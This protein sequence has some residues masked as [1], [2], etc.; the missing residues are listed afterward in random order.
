MDAAR[1]DRSPRPGLFGSVALVAVWGAVL[2]VVTLV[3][4]LLLLKLVAGASID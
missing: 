3:A 2:L 4:G 1:H